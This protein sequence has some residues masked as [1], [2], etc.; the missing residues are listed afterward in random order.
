[1]QEQ[2]QLCRIQEYKKIIRTYKADQVIEKIKEIK[3]ALEVNQEHEK[4]YQESYLQRL[5]CEEC[6]NEIK[7]LRS[8]IYNL[9]REGYLKTAQKL[10]QLYKI[11]VV[12]KECNKF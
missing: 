2:P 7:L 6:R 4:K 5:K 10:I 8:L 1:M 12:Q 9:L 11:D 3:N